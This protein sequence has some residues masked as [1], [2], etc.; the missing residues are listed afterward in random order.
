MVLKKAVI[1][2]AALLLVP[3]ASFGQTGSVFQRG[4]QEFTLGGSGSSDKDFDESSFNASLSYGQFYNTNLEGVI[5]Q[6]IAFVDVPG[7]SDWN[8]S[9]RL[10]AEYHFGQGPLI[11][12]LGVSA[13]YV[14]GD[15]VEDQFIAGPEAGLKYFLNSTTFTFAMAEYQF[16]F[17]EPSDVDDVIDDG[18]FV[19]GLGLGLIF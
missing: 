9:T 10:A 1:V 4:T 14:Y 2:T 8:G 3:A 11:P 13:G 12:L 5:R 15:N 17:D 7:G 18:R 19:Y 16:L 6:D